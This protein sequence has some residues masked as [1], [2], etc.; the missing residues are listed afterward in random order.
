MPL[1]KGSS[2]AV[3]SANISTEMHA[4]KKQAQ[5][6]AIALDMA[7]RMKRKKGAPKMPRMSER[8]EPME[9]IRAAMAKMPS[10]T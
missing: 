6:V 5:A 4:G 1:T 10:K 3:V 2:R 7:R 9:K 8:P